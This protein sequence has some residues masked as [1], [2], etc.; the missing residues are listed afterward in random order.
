MSNL[1]ADTVHRFFIFRHGLATHSKNGY[2]DQVLNATLLEE[3]VP[4]IEKLGTYLKS[5]PRDYAYSS[6]LPRCR[7]TAAIVTKATGASF[8]FDP[9]LNEYHQEQFAQFTERVN[10]FLEDV[11]EVADRLCQKRDC[12]NDPVT[13]WICSH[14]AVIAC[15]KHLLLEGT[16]VQE[17][18]LDYTQPGEVLE[19]WK[20]NTKLHIFN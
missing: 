13:I 9:R 4:A 10:D 2:G 16:H 7:Q 8:T 1:T 12:S 5:I 17:D 6:E 20:K 15:L 3:G 11:V 19:I 18:E 14:G